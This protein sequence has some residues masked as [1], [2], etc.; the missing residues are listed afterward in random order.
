MFVPDTH[1]EPE[2]YRDLGTGTNIPLP[3]APLHHP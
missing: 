2:V 3:M 1:G